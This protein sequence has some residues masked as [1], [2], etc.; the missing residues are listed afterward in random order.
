MLTV[1][2]IEASKVLLCS[3]SNKASKNSGEG[4]FSYDII[5]PSLL[6]IGIPVNSSLDLNF[7]FSAGPV[8]LS[9]ISFISLFSSVLDI[10][11][12][13]SATFLAASI[14]S[15]FNSPLATCFW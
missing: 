11:T 1:L 15:G 14:V 4:S 3:I 12:S 7:L 2:R 9:K 10:F 6:S 13:W 5:L 8:N